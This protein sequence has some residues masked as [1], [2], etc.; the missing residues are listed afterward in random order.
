MNQSPYLKQDYNSKKRWMSYW[1]QIDEI[2]ETK[3]KKI[4]EIGTG[5]GAVNDYLRRAGY[6]ITVCDIDKKLKPDVIADVKNLPF[7][8]NEFDFI[9]CAQVLEH[10]PFSD[11]QLS[12]KNLFRVTKRWVLI[13]LPD[14][15]I[16]NFFISF[17]LIPFIPKITK[18]IKVKLPVKHIFDG[19]HYWE[20][21]KKGYPLK[22]I[23]SAI[24]QAGFKIVKNY[25]PD[26]NPYHHFFVLSKRPCQTENCSP[27]L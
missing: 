9:L 23:K 7:K 3:P 20:I 10:M 8:E 13:T 1:F 4:L 17:K 2:L 5:S 18:T 27:N 26:E 16:F 19:N 22:K 12:L 14:Y 25:T 11:F 15:S 24:K 21:D 6:K